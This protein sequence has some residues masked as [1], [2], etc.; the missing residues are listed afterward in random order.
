MLDRTI[1]PP[2]QHATELSLLTP[3]VVSLSGGNKLYVLRGG[4][5]EVMR[6][7]LI[8][9]AGKWFEPTVG[10]AHFTA[11]Q[12]DKGT[13]N[14][15]SYQLA[16]HFDAFGAHIEVSAGNDFITLTLYTLTKRLV[17]VLPVVI[18]LLT[19]PIFPDHEIEIAKSI[20]VQNLRV[21]EEKTSYLAG[22]HFRKA[23]FGKQHPYGS[24]LDE[25]HVNNIQASDLRAY[26][27]QQLTEFTAIA[28]G[29]I[30][31]AIIQQI[32]TQLSKL[33]STTV[34]E[35]KLLFTPPSVS[36]TYTPKEGSVQS[37][38][39]YGARCINRK[40]ADFFDLLFTTHLL[41]GY[42]G[43]R[44]MKNIREEK[45]LTYGIFASVQ[46]LKNDC[47][48]V[49]GADVNRDNRQ[50]TLDEVNNE[51]MRLAADAVSAHELT[52]ARNHFIGGLQLEVTTA[53]A[54]GDKMKTILLNE[55]P[56]DYYQQM[57]DRVE[58][59]TAEDV[60]QTAVKYLRP[61]SFTQVSVG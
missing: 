43:S 2:F 56:H 39:R 61:Q 30:S 48:F 15:T 51:L 34:A 8:L 27:Q 44:L 1:A 53:F 13:K 20:T 29:N 42:F 36:A 14:K 32:T 57:I 60:Q 54:H 37:T 58:V 26:H 35:K 28:S 19:E 25:V 52:N 23:I 33:P 6:L 45:G 46:P 47:F 49:I 21:N 4:T 3:E 7:E 31:D 55:L 9:P 38:I 40:D 5:Q 11:N 17:E 16:S 12:L 50:L 22:K 41:G 59:I 18:E 10:I 24:E